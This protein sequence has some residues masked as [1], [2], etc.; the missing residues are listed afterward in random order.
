MS[1]IT[2]GT[3]S[4]LKASSGAASLTYRSLRI[5]A[6]EKQPVH[7]SSLS[8]KDT[9]TKTRSRIM[10]EK[11][12]RDNSKE[13]DPVCRWPSRRIITPQEDSALSPCDPIETFT[14]SFSH[15]WPHTHTHTSITVD[16]FPPDTVYN[17]QTLTSSRR[18]PAGALQADVLE[19]LA[20]HGQVDAL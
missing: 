20:A 8:R 14:L 1:A 6:T 7:P 12:S 11:P 5:K 4:Q 17:P 18:P 10:G 9:L 3:G 16:L 13:D 15:S 2:L 19:P